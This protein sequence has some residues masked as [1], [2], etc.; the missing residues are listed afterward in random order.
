MHTFPRLFCDET[1]MPVRREDKKRVHIGQFWT[2]ATD[3]RP[4]GGPAP[5][6]VAYVYAEGRGHR[7]IKA[8]LSDYQG[9]LQ[10]DGYGGYKALAK[11]GR[12]PGPIQLAYCLAHARR[13]FVD[14][15]KA[16]GSCFAQAVIE[17]IAEIYAV[18]ADIRGTSADWRLEVRQAR[19]APLMAVLKREL[20][21][22]VAQISKKSTQAKAIR[23]T[24]GH[25]AGL[26]LFLQD[27]RL[28]V[29]N[30]TVE[31]SIRPIA[32][33]RRNS[34]FAGDDGGAESWSILASLLQTAVLNGVDPYTY[35]L[36]IVEKI[37]SGEVKNH[38]LDQLLAWNWKAARQ[39]DPVA[40]AA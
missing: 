22:G 40:L 35:L 2:H 16:T 30:N 3:D 25:W 6:A 9:L 1:R 39:T 31:R 37:V 20:E 4:W 23:Y 17:R 8:Q 24:L 12:K 13:K 38:E 7:E 21:S 27:G 33:G 29:D 18:E 10:V 19:S 11:T 14:V 15:Y 34:L 36:D 32:L 28:E 5:P 26:N